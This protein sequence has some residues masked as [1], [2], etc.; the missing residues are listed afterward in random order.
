MRCL[1]IGDQSLALACAAALKRRGHDVVGLVAGPRTPANSSAPADLRVYPTLA[2]LSAEPPKDVDL[3]F[4]ITNLRLIAPEI[5]QLPHLAAINF[6]DGPLP[7]YA[8][9]NA[10]VFALL[11]GE[12]EHGISW[13]LMEDVVDAGGVLCQRVFPID[14]NETALTLN[15]KCYEAAL[16]AFEYLIS[17]LPRLP[18]PV[19]RPLDVGTM[20]PRGRR[21]ENGAVISWTDSAAAIERTVR[22]LD[23][24]AYPNPVA[25]CSVRFAGHLLLVPE[26]EIAIGSSVAQ[27]ATIVELGEEGITVVTGNGLLLIPRLIRPN[28]SVLSHGELADLGMS[29]GSAFESI[30]SGAVARIARTHAAV[31]R[32]ETYWMSRLEQ[33]EPAGLPGEPRRSQR[34]ARFSRREVTSPSGMS[35]KA[36]I[37]GFAAWVIRTSQGSSVDIAYSHES[38]GPL[39]D[40]AEA[41]F[42]GSVPVR[43]MVAASSR[44]ADLV[45]EMSSTLDAAAERGTWATDAWTRHHGMRQAPDIRLDVA[46]NAANDGPVDGAALTWV[47]AGP[48]PAIWVDDSRLAEPVVDRILEQIGV[49]LA[50]VAADDSLSVSNLPLMSGAECHRLLVTWN[51]TARPYRSD[52]SVARFIEE[53]V[54]RSPDAVAVTFDGVDL[55]YRDLDRRAN[56]LAHAM[57]EAGVGPDL[58]VG[59]HLSRSLRLPEAVLA[60]HK[61]GGAYLPLDP[62]YPS[63][64]LQFMIEDARVSIVVSDS[65]DSL[66]VPKGTRVLDLSA[67]QNPPLD[68]PPPATARGQNLAY[69]IY[70]SGSTGR[71]KG[72]M[73]EHRNVSNFFVAMDEVLG[74][75]PGVWL[76]VTS[77]SFDIS[78]LE[79]LWTLARG[80][81]VIIHR[82]DDRNALFKSARAQGVPTSVS[83]LVSAYG[84]THLQCT[85]SR[86]TMTLLEAGGREAMGRLRHLLLGGEALPTALARD[87]LSLLPGTLHNMYGPTE[88]TVWST[89]RV[90]TSDDPSPAIGRPLANTTLYVLDERRGA[91]PVGTPGELYIGGAGVVRGYLNRAELTAERFVLNHFGE[92]DSRLYRTGDLVRYRD[93]GVLEFIGRADFQIKLRGHRIELGEIEQ[94]LGDLAGVQ[95]AIAI[96][97]EDA[98]GDQRLVGYVVGQADLDGAACREQL[99]QLLPEYAVPSHVVVLPRF[100]L[101]PNLKVDRKAL[102][103]PPRERQASQGEPPTTAAEIT[104]AGIWARLL[105]VPASR[106]DNFFDLGGHSLLAMQAH[107]ELCASFPDADL[108]VV[109]LF[110]LPTM[111]ALATYLSGSAPNERTVPVDQFVRPEAIYFG[112]ADRPLFGFFHA[113]AVTASK[114][115]VLFCYPIPPKYQLCYR[116]FQRLAMLLTR[117]GYDVLRFD[118]TGVGDSAGSASDASLERWSQ[119]TFLAAEWLRGRCK[120]PSIS[121]VGMS[122]GAAQAAQASRLF[123]TQRL[124][125]WEPVIE[126]S[127]YLREISGICRHALEPDGS[128]N[129]YGYPISRKLQAELN[130]LSLTATP[131]QADQIL[132]LQSRTN[133]ESEALVV[134]AS[135]VMVDTIPGFGDWATDLR[136]DVVVVPPAHLHRIHQFLTA[137]T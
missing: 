36:L 40:G 90:V 25:V 84:V 10:P 128:H 96:V 28:G 57:F 95:E 87:V 52:V 1:I 78:V 133:A 38:L 33:L 119:D 111:R 67:S 121:M 71:P 120:F 19:R 61:A 91:V 88:T 43:L 75:E 79:L 48:K 12:A 83:G 137:S 51:D 24:G 77:L 3:L 94:R 125:L 110:R 44:F 129:F 118:P 56:G 112:P 65:P 80:Y 55:T 41:W 124:V 21:P 127:S 20:C 13:H 97:R 27:P 5:L 47:T 34:P 126:G 115:A 37:A 46:L 16:S 68:A 105:G 114:G 102:P 50:A 92:P 101:T 135:N 99:R 109:D 108:R 22:A 76:A 14:R 104:I 59:I 82:D 122:L 8:G 17:D 26:V 49:L 106:D 70:T 23:H 32:H 66:V 117:S 53:Q 89:T 81:R 42:S 73:I 18:E 86:A 136:N 64:R 100:P 103:A 130:S 107:A 98:P 60:V 39:R 72:V 93:D 15:A 85:P 134:S 30:S 123:R 35:K 69:V 11:A 113:S 31:G 45:Q 6:H 63:D 116:A 7:R 58:I 9:L 74:T 29:I 2:T 62:E 131:P 4:S 54:Q 132:L